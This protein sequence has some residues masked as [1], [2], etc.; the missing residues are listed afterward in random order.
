MPSCGGYAGKVM[1]I[2]LTREAI[3]EYPWSAEERKAY[4]GGKAMAARILCDHLRGWETPLSEENWVVISTGPLVGTGA[5]GS[6]RFDM[7]ALSPRD[8]LPAFSNCGGSFGVHLKKA[9]YDA[10]ILTGRC[11][12]HR[13][14]EIRE[15]AVI[16]HDAARLW[17]TLVSECRELL[18]RHLGNVPFGM[19][20][21]GPAGENL[22]R[23]ASLA[24]D[25]H[26]GGRAGMGAVLG[27][28]NLKAITVCGSKKIPIHAPEKAA[29]LNREW[30]DFMK[31][32]AKSETLSKL[33][34]TGCPIRCARHAPPADPLINELGMDAI[35]ASD[36][37]QWAAERRLAGPDI[38]RDM[39]YR[40]GI[41]SQ[42][43]DG[44]AH[45]KGNG[46]SRRGGSY[47]AIADA[48]HLPPDDPE[49]DG[50]CRSLVEAVSAAGQCMFTVN[51]LPS[52]QD[53]GCMDYLLNMLTFVTGMQTDLETLLQVGEG[54]Q[55]L[56]QQLLGKFGK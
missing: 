42:L 18:A 3:S 45:R 49:T 8:G 28:K 43:A 54:C 19:L 48:F 5:P 27:W 6:A 11:K 4:L 53:G 23:F 7:A 56:V 12:E 14:L 25:G 51:A 2:D 20:C 21:I 9:G 15:D 30:L 33:H 37:L 35:A 44:A 31:G 46:G 40:R 38:Y 36:A 41:G 26:T 29:A 32:N 55:A 39:A 16:F 17:G 10:L 50:F 24:A 1:K 52:S 47:R 13:W 22:V 34:C